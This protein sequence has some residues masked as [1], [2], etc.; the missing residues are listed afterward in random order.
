MLCIQKVMYLHDG[1]QNV[2]VLHL[3]SANAAQSLLKAAYKTGL[4]LND[5]QYCIF[6]S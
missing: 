2:S 6:I 4:H 5:E 1:L 3:I